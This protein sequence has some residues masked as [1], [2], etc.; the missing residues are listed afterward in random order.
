VYLV[1]TS[2]II[3][4]LQGRE[5]DKTA[6]YGYLIA[7]KVAYGI[8]ILT[9]FEVLQGIK[10]E[11][12][13]REI[14]KALGTIRHYHLPAQEETYERAANLYR[15]CR[16]KGITPRSS[17]DLLIAQ[18]ALEYGLILLHNDH[19]F[20]QIARAIPELRILS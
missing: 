6:L 3:D 1:D 20:N 9:Y 12:A 7:N 14:K 5:N 17:I 10:G 2:V 11:K 15:I 13:H 19:D 16:A 4:V 8:S 18:T